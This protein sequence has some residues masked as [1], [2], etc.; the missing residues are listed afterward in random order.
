MIDDVLRTL[1]DRGVEPIGAE[2][3]PRSAHTEQ[4]RFSAGDAQDSNGRELG[5]RTDFVPPADATE[6]NP[7]PQAELGFPG[8]SSVIGSQPVRTSTGN[9]LEGLLNTYSLKSTDNRA[10][11]GALWVEATDKDR[12]LSRHLT[13][14]GFTYARDRGWWKR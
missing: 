14:L 1:R 12:Q 7:R 13:A 5:P 3:A 4:R 11:G 10:K 9:G 6:T 8:A 2:G